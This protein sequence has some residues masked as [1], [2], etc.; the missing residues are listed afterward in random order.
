M[1][2]ILFDSSDVKVGLS[3]TCSCAPDL[4]V[5]FRGLSNWDFVWSG[6]QFH[7]N[8]PNCTT[9][10]HYHQPPSIPRDGHHWGGVDLY[11]LLVSLSLNSPAVTLGCL[12]DVSVA[13]AVTPT[14]IKWNWRAGSCPW[15]IY[16]WCIVVRSILWYFVPLFI[17][18]LYWQDV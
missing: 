6:D 3:M 12:W 17:V 11:Y 1:C 2:G 4:C 10:H 8:Y 14:L 15:N 13:Q 5:L 16:A 9:D 7:N 18:H